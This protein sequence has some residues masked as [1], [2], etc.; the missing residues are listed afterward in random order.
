MY[1][2][3][4]SGPSGTLR[5]AG[6]RFV[7]DAHGATEVSLPAPPAAGRQIMV[8]SEVGGRATAPTRAPILRLST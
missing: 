2:V 4:M 3:W 1:E 8:T 5:P 7:V 6:V